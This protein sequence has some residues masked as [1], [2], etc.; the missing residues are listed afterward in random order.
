[1]CG[2]ISCMTA[3]L[4]LI[5]E[6][7]SQ[8]VPAQPTA[9]AALCWGP[10]PEAVPCPGVCRHIAP[11]PA[12]SE[13][14]A[15]SQNASIGQAVTMWESCENHVRIMWESC[16]NHAHCRA[17]ALAG[18]V[19]LDDLLRSLST[20][21]ILCSYD[22]ENSPCLL[23]GLIYKMWICL[24]QRLYENKNLSPYALHIYCFHQLAI[25]ENWPIQSNR[26]CIL[27]LYTSL[28]MKNVTRITL[29]FLNDFFLVLCWNL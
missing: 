26:K 2:M 8:A 7:V 9:S 13:L 19:G 4:D 3:L 29:L 15:A 24:L 11:K 17:P 18:G 28:R 14:P 20:P 1:M 22:S 25:V 23:E 6:E 27:L 12:N 16:E 10:I 5:N 21:A